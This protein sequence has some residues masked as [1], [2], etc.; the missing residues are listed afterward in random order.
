[1]TFVCNKSQGTQH[2]KVSLQNQLYNVVLTPGLQVSWLPARVST[3]FQD[4]VVLY[5]CSHPAIICVRQ[6]T[7]K[8]SNSF[9]SFAVGLFGY[10][11]TAGR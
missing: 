3:G 11:P 9:E 5:V 8:L 1:M 7:S 2:A 6:V 10:S 4:L